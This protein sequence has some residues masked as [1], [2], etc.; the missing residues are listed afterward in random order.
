MNVPGGGIVKVEA[1]ANIS[2]HVGIGAKV[3]VNVP[4]DGTIGR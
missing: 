1:A 4:G 3:T 2:A